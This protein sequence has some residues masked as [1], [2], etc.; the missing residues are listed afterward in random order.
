MFESAVSV[1]FCPAL[2]DTSR[3]RHALS[4]SSP[5]RPP[6]A[7]RLHPP[8]D[9]NSYT[10]TH[11]LTPVAKPNGSR[12]HQS[13]PLSPR[14]LLAFH[15]SFLTRTRTTYIFRHAST[16]HAHVASLPASP[17]PIHPVNISHALAHPRAHVQAHRKSAYIRD[18]SRDTA[19]STPIVDS[20][21]GTEN[22]RFICSNVDKFEDRFSSR[23]K[24]ALIESIKVLRPR[25][26][27]TSI[28]RLENHR[29]SDVRTKCKSIYLHNSGSLK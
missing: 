4:M 27:S 22:Y 28:R 23:L 14:A 10:F 13:F 3:L 1:N 29:R 9:R 18:V 24:S 5:P 2:K 21:R 20:E 17:A 26:Q 16:P 25:P 8:S 11:P 15:A 6:R 12:Q 19:P 7:R